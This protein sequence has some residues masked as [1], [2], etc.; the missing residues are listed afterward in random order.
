MKAEAPQTSKGKNKQTNKHLG[1]VPS[2]QKSHS[3]QIPL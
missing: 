1:N 2:T 3:S